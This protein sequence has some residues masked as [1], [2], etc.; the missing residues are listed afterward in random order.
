MKGFIGDKKG[1]TYISTA[2]IIFIMSA[3]FAVAFQFAKTLTVLRTVRDD[4]TRILDSCAVDNAKLIYSSIKQGNNR[5][6]EVKGK[7]FMERYVS[8]TDS[9]LHASGISLADKGGKTVYIM[10]F[11]KV[12]LDSE[13]ELRLK[14][15]FNIKIPF[16]LF[17]LKVF[18]IT[19]PMTVK[20]NYVNYLSD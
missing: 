1:I 18:E 13:N 19:V 17:N 3:L 9:E 16:R 4:A 14:A 12:S 2:V 6:I 11:P 20:S 10:S 5:I 15:E 7:S 8:E